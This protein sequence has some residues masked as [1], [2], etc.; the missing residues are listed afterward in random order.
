[1][2]DFSSGEGS[3]LSA[4]GREMPSAG[5]GFLPYAGRPSAPGRDIL[6]GPENA[7]LVQGLCNEALTSMPDAGNSVLAGGTQRT[8]ALPEGT[9]S[10]E[11]D[12]QWP[13]EDSFS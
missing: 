5:Q 9:L 7:V 2:R 13:D 10:N 1:M 12:K 6:S 8:G 3:S 4:P 11:C